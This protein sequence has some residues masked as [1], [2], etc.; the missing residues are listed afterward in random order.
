MLG[1]AR[2]TGQTVGAVL[3]AILFSFANVH[4]GRGPVIALALAACFAAVAGA[5]STLRLWHAPATG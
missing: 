3:L 2:L 5:F 1:T 4:D